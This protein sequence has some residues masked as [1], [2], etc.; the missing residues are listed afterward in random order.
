IPALAPIR[1]RSPT[2]ILSF[3]PPDRV[4]MIDAPPP[5]S[6]PLPTT[7]AYPAFDHAGTER[8][9]IKIAKAFMHD[10]RARSQ[11]GPEPYA[12]RICNS[13]VRRRHIISHARKLIHACH[14]KR[15]GTLSRYD[16]RFRYTRAFTG[17]E[18]RP[19]NVR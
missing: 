7:G 3:P 2:V 14:L 8:T 6:L 11:V 15:K 16:S 18:C 17:P 1:Q 19:G 10:G 5:T 9:C 4:P 13:H 12:I